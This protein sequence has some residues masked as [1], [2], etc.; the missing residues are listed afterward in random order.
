MKPF[1]LLPGTLGTL[2]FWLPAQWCLTSSGSKQ[3]SLLCA[4]YFFAYSRSF[5]C[6][7][8]SSSRGD[9]SG[10][11]AVYPLQAIATCHPTACSICGQ[12][13]IAS[14]CCQCCWPP[15]GGCQT[16]VS[17]CQP[18]SCCWL[19]LRELCAYHHRVTAAA[20]VAMPHQVPEARAVRV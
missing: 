7:F 16:L 20:S 1:Y 15:A 3:Y 10:N 6:V 17:T 4:T 8:K 13:T 5:V 2:W 9:A 14:G 11:T 12:L 19:C 18:P